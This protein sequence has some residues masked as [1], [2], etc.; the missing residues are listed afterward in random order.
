MHC[1]PFAAFQ[2]LLYIASQRAAI[3]LVPTQ[4]QVVFER[5]FDESGGMQLVVHAPFGSR[6]NRAW[7]FAMRKR[8]CRSFDFELQATADDDGFILSLGPQHSFPIE[9]LFPMLRTDNVQ[10]LLEQAL[11]DVPMFQVRWRWNVTR[12]LLVARQRNGKKVPPALQRFRSDDLL[13]SVF[14]KLTGCQENIT[15]DHV[16][17]DHPLVQQTM[18]DCL[19]EALDL[20]GLC[21]VL[22]R[23]ERSEIA[24]TP[25]D[26]REPSP[27]AY[28]LLNANPYAFL[29][30]GEVQ[31]RRTRA[32]ATRRSLNIESVSDLGSARPGGD[33]TGRRRST[34][35]GAQCGRTP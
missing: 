32:V 18:H 23:I 8:F 10:N 27:F 21:E 7:G 19:H 9:S 5:F 1:T 16:L 15:G 33:R 22:G 30:G 26:S 24:L 17:P 35:A 12:A 11:L 29:D 25:R 31:E 14:P 28:E 2:I 20:E 34:A 6:I 13:T 3:G 4:R